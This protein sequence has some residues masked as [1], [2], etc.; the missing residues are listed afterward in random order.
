MANANEHILTGTLGAALTC[1]KC[2]HGLEE[3]SHR[4]WGDVPPNINIRGKDPINGVWASSTLEIVGFEI[5]G[6]YS[7]VCDHQGMVFGVS[8]RSLLGKYRNRVVRARCRRLRCKNAGSINKYN[9]LFKEQV[10]QVISERDGFFH[11][12]PSIA[13]SQLFQWPVG[14]TL[15]DIFHSAPIGVPVEDVLQGAGWTEL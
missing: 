3:V 6:F 9:E 1:S 4:A 2:D 11:V 13:F 12:C 10:R 5:L 8:L 15:E 14:S 7:S